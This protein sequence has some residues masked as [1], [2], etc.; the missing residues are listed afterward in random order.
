MAKFSGRKV[1]VGIGLETSAR[2]TAAAKAYW[3]PF[4]DAN[5]QDKDTPLYNESAYGSIV[6]NNSKISTLI[7]GEGNVTGKLYAKGLYYILALIFGQIATT[8]EDIGS[9]TGANQHVFALLNSNEHLSATLGV[10][11][12]NAQYEYAFAMIDSATITWTPDA[13]PQVELNFISKKGVSDADSVSFVADSEFI[14]KQAV[15]K[16][17]AN[18]AGL[19]GASAATGIKSFSIT[20]TK[21]LSPQQTMDSSDTYGEIFNTDFEVTGSIEKLVS[22]T[23]YRGYALADTIQAMEFT[24]TDS[25]NKAG[26]TTATSLNFKLSRVAFDSYVANRGL[27]DIATETLNFAA[28]LDVTTPADTVAATLVNKY[29][30]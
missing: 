1:N 6:K 27:G 15:L 30:Y 2:G 25:V 17:A 5:F 13:F 11:D 22:D 28:L 20:F 16:L 9:D 24:L 12:G 19:S 8:T 29:D 10:K 26:S 23:T 21:T 7:S 14:P 3:Y 18:L 4:L